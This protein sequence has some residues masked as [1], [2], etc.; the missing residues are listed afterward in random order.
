[1]NDK[2]LT[3][4]WYWFVNIPHIGNRTKV[5]LIERFG[6]PSRVYDC[7]YEDL[8]DIF[9]DKQMISFLSSKDHHKVMQD[10]KDLKNE[11]YH[12]I[13]WESP[14]YPER[15]RSLYD[16]P[17]GFYL[18]GRLPSPHMPTVAVVGS[19]RASPYGKYVADLMAGDLAEKGVSIISGMAAGIDTEAHKSALGHGGHSLGIL[20][21]GIDSMY[22][23]TN[24]NLYLDMYNK[25]GILSEF[26]RGVVNKAG[27]FP[28]RNRLISGIADIVL[29]VEA[30]F[31]SG[32]LITADQGIEQGKEVFAVP[33]R[34]NDPMSQGCNHL[35]A[36]GASVAEDSSVLLECLRSQG[37][38]LETTTYQSMNNENL[39]YS[40]D[41]IKI[42][43]VLDMNKAVGFQEL[44]VKTELSYNVLQHIL[45]KLEM[46]NSIR[47]PQQ[48]M[49]ILNKM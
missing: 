13:H 31:R 7:S 11:G 22:P 18:K 26:N 40:E 1:M 46:N 3:F 42:L 20:G 27:L 34:I 17:Y 21:G 44:L 28:M 29:V 14:D 37:Y 43:N 2:D 10:L 5:K 35:I 32:S 16:P 36:Q 33:G 19:R 12:F 8:V 38:N 48:N 25:G 6:H 9:D 30:G 23:K 47:S 4:Y 49:Y 41:E 24:W 45:M 39:N 15:F